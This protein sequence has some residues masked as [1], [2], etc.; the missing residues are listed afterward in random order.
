MLAQRCLQV[1]NI[2]TLG[3]VILIQSIHLLLLWYGFTMEMTCD[4]YYLKTDRMLVSL[5]ASACSAITQGV[6]SGQ[7]LRSGLGGEGI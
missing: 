3:N 7:T 4:M 6:S 2:N 5:V 1:V